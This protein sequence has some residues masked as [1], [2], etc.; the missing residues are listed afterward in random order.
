MNVSSCQSDGPVVRNHR[1]RGFTIVEVLT[2]L[3]LLSLLAS[4]IL[5]RF[6]LSRMRSYHSN[7]LQ[8]VHNI[9]TALQ[10]YANNNQG[11]YPDALQDLKDTTPPYLQTLP[12][13]PSSDASYGY[14]LSPEATLYTVH[15]QGIHHRQLEGEVE[16]GFPQFY[17]SGHLDAS[18]NP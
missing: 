10:I 2:I 8:N 9:G 3:V 12:I 5:P 18:G 11:K 7:C 4:L 16:E 14:T 1:A 13:C 15:C 6:L 17:S